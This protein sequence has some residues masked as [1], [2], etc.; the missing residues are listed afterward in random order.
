MRV[1][2]VNP[3]RILITCALYS[4]I[5]ACVTHI[6]SWRACVQVSRRQRRRSRRRRARKR[7]LLRF[8][9]KVHASRP[10]RPRPGARPSRQEAPSTGSSPTLASRLMVQAMKRRPSYAVLSVTPASLGAL[11]PNLRSPRTLPS[12]C[13]SETSCLDAGSSQEVVP[14]AAGRWAA[15]P[16]ELSFCHDL[17]RLAQTINSITGGSRRGFEVCSSYHKRVQPPGE[18]GVSPESRHVS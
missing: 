1:R 7:R 15:G 8:M 9:R 6:S 3:H 5:F 2:I 14:P 16:R 17:I 13:A 10:V 11:R 4:S 12:P 18:R